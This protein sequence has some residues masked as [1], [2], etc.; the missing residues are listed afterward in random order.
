MTYRLLS[1]HG[2]IHTKYKMNKNF[3]TS[4]RNK[5]SYNPVNQHTENRTERETSER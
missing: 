1:V 5:H 4:D 3:I 2:F